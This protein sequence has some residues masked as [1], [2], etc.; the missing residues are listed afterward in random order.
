MGSGVRTL[1]RR[2]RRLARHSPGQQPDWTPRGT[3]VAARALPQQSQRHA[4]PTSPPAAAWT[5][6]CTAWASRSA[7]TTTTAARTSTS[8]RSKATGCFTTMGG[9]KFRDVTKPRA[10]TTR[11]SAPAPPGSITTRTASSICS[12][13]ITCNG[14]RT[15][16]S[17]VLAGRCDQVLLHAG[18]VQGN[19]L[20]ALSQSRRRKIRGRQPE[21]RRGRSDAAS[22]SASRSSTSTVTAGPTCSWPMTRSRT[23][24]IA[25]TGT[26]RFG[27]EGMEAGVAFG[28]D[29]VARG[30]MG[31]DAADYDRSGRPHL[32]VGNFSNQML[33]L[34]HNEGNG[35]FVDEA[36]ASSVGRASL[37]TLAFGVFFFDYDLDGLSGHLLGQRP[38]RGGDQPGPAEGPVQAA[39]AAV[40]QPGQG[41]VRRRV[42]RSRAQLSQADR[43]S[44]RGLRRL[45]SRRRSRRRRHHQPW[46]CYVC[47]ATTAATATT[48]CACRTAGS[49]VQ[50]RRHRRRACG[51]RAPRASSGDVVRSG[52][53]YCSQSDLALT[54]G[55]G[56]DP[57]A[58]AIE[59]DWPS[60]AKQKLGGVPANQILTIQE[61]KGIVAK[62]AGTK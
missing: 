62:A 57:G 23:S 20:E 5:S 56:K 41:Q 12:S 9:G 32:L 21:S 34:Y 42:T 4:S 10:S 31:V 58:T 48:G 51:S 17:L 3:Q 54:F 25:T 1:R 2:R 16:R 7:I 50:S 39:A 37:L 35:L 14:A 30:A 26:A 60:G 47:S 53:S 19:Q 28:E 29:G 38:H 8:R 55:L 6:R 27:E 46:P 43:G 36:P 22:R 40:P 52:S 33:G 13:P 49:E 59:I 15:R 61:G 44:R 45:R 18:I 11:A 24:S